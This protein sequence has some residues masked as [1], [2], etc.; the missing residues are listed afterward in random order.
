LPAPGA[1]L[2]NEN[3]R[4]S[5]GRPGTRAPHLWLQ[6]DGREIS[7]LDLFGG[8]FTLLAGP[9]AEAWCRGALG[10]SQR[11]GMAID[12]HCVHAAVAASSGA[13]AIVDPAGRFPAAYGISRS[14]AVLVRPDGFVAWRATTRQAA[15]TEEISTALAAVLCRETLGLP[16]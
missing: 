1:A 2:T 16:A 4:E 9:E 15:S 10:A 13:T 11:F 6:R 7:T 8:N 3:P 5:K 12:I 14:G